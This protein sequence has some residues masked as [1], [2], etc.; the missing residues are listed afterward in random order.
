MSKIFNR[1][2][3][4]FGGL[5]SLTL[6]GAADI[7]ASGISAIFWFYMASL[8]GAEQYGQVSYF[9]SIVSVASTISLFGFENVISVYVA[10]KVRLEPPVYIIS[11]LSAITTAL[12]L[13]IM[14][15]KIGI[16][17]YVLGATFFGLAGAEILANGLYKSYPKYLL[18]HKI[19][20][21]V[22]SLGFYHLFGVDGI[23]LGMGVSFFP[24]L[25]RICR[26]FKDTKIN[27]SLLRPRFGF[28]LNSYVLNLSSV[29]NGSIDKLIIGPLVGFTLLGNYQLGIQF[30]TVLHIVPS[31]VYKYTLPQDA[32]G[33]PN[34][35]LKKMTIL[36]STGLAIFGIIFAPIIIPIL[37]PRYLESIQVI[38]IIS[39]SIIPTTVNLMFVSKFLA[40]E[41]NRIVLISSGIH[42]GVLIPVLVLLGRIY[43]I[44]GMAAAFVLA[45]SIETCYYWMAD[46]Y[47]RSNGSM[48]IT[49]DNK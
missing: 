44:N 48:D 15:D 18:S 36:F 34:K 1:F 22:L 12:V 47:S 35:K 29:F 42:M 27:F 6:I 16:S 21:I 46:R 11:I 17:I 7:A 38:Q 23:F 13:F 19:L 41:K 39:I 14:F 40:A 2:K 30:L 8:L 9:L 4:I 20:M 28:I 24:Y 3:A 26:G 5:K 45:I 25:I 32:G 31:I 49:K 33:N 43:G 37:F 10:K